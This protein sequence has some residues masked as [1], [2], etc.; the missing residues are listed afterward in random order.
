[1]SLSTR[2]TTPFATYY[3]VGTRGDVWWLHCIDCC[4]PHS[5][6]VGDQH[7]LQT[8]AGAQRVRDVL[9]SLGNSEATKS[10]LRRHRY[11]VSI[12]IAWWHR[13]CVGVNI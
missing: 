3:M 8:H 10:P 11:I 4:H 5:G 13:I 12:I 2:N 9:N 1:M 7:A 6:Q